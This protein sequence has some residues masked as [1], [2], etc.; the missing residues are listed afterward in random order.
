MFDEI[1]LGQGFRYLTGAM[2]VGGGVLMLFRRTLT[3]GAAMLACTMVGAAV[4]DV[5]VVG[6]PV[7][8]IIPLLLLIAV[9]TTWATSVNR[10]R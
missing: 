8:M 5:A 7:F 10:S 9:A 6:Q 2:Q 3:L 1:G 4:V